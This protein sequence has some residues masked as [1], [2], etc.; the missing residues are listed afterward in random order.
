MTP[1]AYRLIA[2]LVLLVHWGVVA[3]VVGGFVAVLLGGW[4]GWPWVRR[5]TWRL[6]HLFV[7]AWVVVQ[8]WLGRACFLTDWEMALRLRGGDATYSGGMI[9]HWMG[10][11]LYFEA[12][13]WVFS[14]IYTVFGM[15][16]VG[17]W[18]WIRPTA[19]ESRD[20]QL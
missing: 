10:E 13:M 19:R 2:D 1:T 5:R 12:P 15:L 14:L 8:A 11:L 16:V 6:V 17:S 3:F 20:D 7:L 18:I 9:A 4:R